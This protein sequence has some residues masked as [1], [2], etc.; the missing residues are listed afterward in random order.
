M[1]CLHLYPEDH[2]IPDWELHRDL[3]VVLCRDCSKVLEIEFD[4]QSGET[5]EM[6]PTIVVETLY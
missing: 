1:T 2:R 3:R 4:F 5:L 6:V